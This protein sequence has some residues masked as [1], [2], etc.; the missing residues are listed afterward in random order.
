[1]VIADALARSLLRVRSVVLHGV[2]DGT[3]TGSPGARIAATI[4]AR[5]GV[6]PFVIDIFLNHTFKA[7]L[8]IDTR[9]FAKHGELDASKRQQ[10]NIDELSN[11][12]GVICVAVVFA[13]GIPNFLN[14]F[15]RPIAVDDHG[16]RLKRLLWGRIEYSWEDI[17]ALRRRPFPSGWI[18]L[19]LERHSFLQIHRGYFLVS[20]RDDELA[21]MVL[22]KAQEAGVLVDERTNE[23]GT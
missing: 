18:E 22:L 9:R 17:L 11:L 15:A 21:N 12:W 13:L 3:V 7:T 8:P 4:L 6:E 1:M 19:D 5:E 16:I 20:S 14:I 10:M 2:K 23:R